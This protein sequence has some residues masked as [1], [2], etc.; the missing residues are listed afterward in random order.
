ML[1]QL[2][3]SELTSSLASRKTSARDV[4]RACLDQIQRQDGRSHAFLNCDATDALVQADAADQAIA[5]GMTH[6]QQPLLGVPIAI[7]DVIAV[8]GQPLTCASKMLENFISPY[9]AAV[10]E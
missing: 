6:A 2:S 1:N 10:I 9:D 3:I 4:T 8:K 5:S 7:K